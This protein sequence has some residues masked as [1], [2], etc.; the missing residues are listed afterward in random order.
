VGASNA[1]ACHELLAGPRSGDALEVDPRQRSRKHR[2]GN[3]QPNSA[4]QN[5]QTVVADVVEQLGGTVKIERDDD[6]LP[7]T[8]NQAHEV[9]KTMAELADEVEQA[10]R[11]LISTSVDQPD[12][13]LRSRLAMGQTLQEL[14]AVREAENELRQ[15]AGER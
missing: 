13:K 6:F 10:S 4:P 14:R 8:T 12:D 2:P 5:W 11:E 3:A 7:V 15:N 9:L 1:R